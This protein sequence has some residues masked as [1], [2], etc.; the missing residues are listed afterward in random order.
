MDEAPG[1]LQQVS[2]LLR[3]ISVVDGHE[4][5]HVSFLAGGFG[6]SEIGEGGGGTVIPL[7]AYY[8]NKRKFGFHPNPI[9][10][11]WVTIPIVFFGTVMVRG[12][13]RQRRRKKDRNKD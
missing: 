8:E 7:G 1:V 13:I 6:S 4:M 5:E 2:P 9:V 11:I 3:Q 12:I 10:T